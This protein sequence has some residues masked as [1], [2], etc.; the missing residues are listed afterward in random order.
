MKFG[1]PMKV[2]RRARNLRAQETIF[3][4]A[5]FKL[6]AYWSQAQAAPGVFSQ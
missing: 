3:D 5:T 1:Y 4:F 2:N 6:S